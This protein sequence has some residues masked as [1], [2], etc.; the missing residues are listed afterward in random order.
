MNTTT[1]L[2]PSKQNLWLEIAWVGLSV[3]EEMGASEGYN[4]GASEGYHVGVTELSVGKELGA[5]EGYNVGEEDGME[6]VGWHV[7]GNRLRGFGFLQ[8]AYHTL[9]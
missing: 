3:G 8:I 5:S 2:C 7:G 4:V 9:V 1:I 6:V